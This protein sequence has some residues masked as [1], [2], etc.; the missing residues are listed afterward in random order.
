M[1]GINQGF[2]GGASDKKLACQ[3]RRHKRLGFDPWV[4][5][6]PWRRAAAAAAKSLQSCPTLWDPIDGSPP[7]DSPG[8]NTGVGYYLVNMWPRGTQV[9]PIQLATLLRLGGVLSKSHPPRK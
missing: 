8:K 3:F 2:P 9:S 6:I 4:E 5:K 1:W 7:W